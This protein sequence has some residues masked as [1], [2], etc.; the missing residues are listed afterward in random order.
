MQSMWEDGPLEERLPRCKREWSQV[1]TRINSLPKS[2][3]GQSISARDLFKGVKLDYAKGICLSFDD[4]A[5]MYRPPTK[6][7]LME[8]RSTGAIALCPKDNYSKSWLFMDLNIGYASTSMKS[9]AC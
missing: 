9:I 7:N 1:C 3:S 4:Y 8:S 5:Q 6:S 2:N